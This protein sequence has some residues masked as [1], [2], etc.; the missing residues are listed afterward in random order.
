[1][2]K[3]SPVLAACALTI[4]CFTMA[5]SSVSGRALG[6]VS[7]SLG[8]VETAA[9][10]TAVA[11]DDQQLPA[12]G[13]TPAAAPKAAAEAAATIRTDKFDYQPGETAII[14]GTGFA[15]G[16]NVTL[17]VDHAN[18][19]AD[20]DGHLPFIALA[21]GSG[22]IE[23]Q[24][25]VNPDDSLHSIFILSAVGETS[26]RKATS[27]FTDVL[28]RFVDDQGA[29][30]E[31]GQKDLNF[32]TLKPLVRRRSPLPGGGTIPPG[33]LELGRRVRPHRHRRQT[34]RQ[35]QLCLL[36]DCQGDASDDV[37]D[38]DVFVRQ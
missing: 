15:P 28:Q 5:G 19:L 18:G 22:N 4:T 35:G 16:E 17:E 13:I 1:M 27:V 21:D 23:S 3:V 9:P 25:F 7:A 32:F 31:P 37:R 11:V 36:R 26:G 2:R 8:A 24:W 20:G 38:P 29:D 30:D 34:G 12:P 10:A 14:T 33:G 6:L